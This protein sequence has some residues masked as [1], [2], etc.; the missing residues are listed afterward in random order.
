MLCKTTTTLLSLA[1]LAATT[2]A[3]PTF[4]LRGLQGNGPPELAGVA[5]EIPNQERVCNAVRSTE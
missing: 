1:V 4:G 5:V 2:T 3:A